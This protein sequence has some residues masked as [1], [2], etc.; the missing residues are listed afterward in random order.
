MAGNVSLVGWRD[1]PEGSM[2]V[3][4]STR[5]RTFIDDLARSESG[6]L[7]RQELGRRWPETNDQLA[8]IARYALLPAGKLLRPIMTLHAAEAVGGAPADVLAAA[9]GMEYLHGAAEL[10][11]DIIDDV[12]FRRGRPAAHVTYG[13]PSA[14]LTGDHLICRAFAA[15][16][17]E[18][19]AASPDHVVAA[20]A[21]L[22]GAGSDLCR[23]QILEAQMVGDLDA[24]ARWYQDM[25]R[26]KTGALFRVVCHIGALLGGADGDFASA[27]ARYGEHVGLA[28]QIRDD[29]L[30]YA[31]TPEQTGK[32]AANDLGNGRPTL[33]L[34]LA[35]DAAAGPERR[36]LLAVLRRHGS[37]DGDVQWVNDLLEE[38]GA[39]IGARRQMAAHAERARAELAVLDP[40][41]SVDVLAGIAYWTTSEGS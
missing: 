2:T 7:L 11:D 28:F 15:I 20:V 5:Y 6:R 37:G 12:A 27:L 33:P 16:V 30:D 36:E 41:P 39:A 23:G 21:A 3:A 18:P 38:T 25:I 8:V 31:A 9:L 35:Y 17:D 24:G 14:I 40:S 22:A 4:G 1:L 32:P 19:G 10:H 26:L 29:L 13:V 34:L